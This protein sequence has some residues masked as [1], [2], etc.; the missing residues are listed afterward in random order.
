M[1]NFLRFLFGRYFWIQ[2]GSELSYKGQWK[3][4]RFNGYGHL[5]YKNG[6]EYVGHFVDGVK[7]GNGWYSSSSGYEYEGDWH[8]GKQSGKAKIQYKNGDV[9][10]GEVKDSLRDGFGELY[11]VSAARNFKG[12]W[13]KNHIEKDAEI[14]DQN[15][16]FKGSV[17]LKS[18]VGYGEIEYKDGSIYIGEIRAFKRQGKGILKMANGHSINGIWN[19]NINVESAIIFDEYGF[20]WDGNLENMQPVGRMKTTRP[21]GIIYDSVWR[22]GA[23]LQSLSI[24]KISTKMRNTSETRNI[25]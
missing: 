18:N 16:L 15:W 8:K 3:S 7:H 17:D 9:Y 14:K 11:Q 13:I 2:C 6:S 22:D 10:T 23:M 12:T 19:N 24:Q 5:K 21:D 20:R 25:N 4:G 1:L